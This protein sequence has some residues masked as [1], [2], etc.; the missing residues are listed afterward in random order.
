MLRTVSSGLGVRLGGQVAAGVFL[1]ACRRVSQNPPGARH[2]R[3]RSRG[4]MFPS[5]GPM[6][7]APARS[8]SGT[9]SRV[10]ATGEGR[11]DRPENLAVLCL[12]HHK[13]PMMRRLRQPEVR[14][15]LFFWSSFSRRTAGCVSRGWRASRCEGRPAG[16]SSSCNPAPSSKAQQG[17]HHRD[18]RAQ[19]GRAGG[20]PPPRPTRASAARRADLGGLHR[21]SR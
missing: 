20:C 19:D 16:L 4:W 11:A 8:A 5:F 15:P 9:R 1:R 2:R 10:S 3:Y 13:A 7:A 14:N 21:C 18:A 12:A 6:V 17:A